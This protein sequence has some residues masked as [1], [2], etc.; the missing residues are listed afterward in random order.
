MGNQQSMGAFVAALQKQ[1]QQQQAPDPRAEI[2]KKRVEL[3]MSKNDTKGKQIN[4]DKLVPDEVQQRKTNEANAK[5]SQ[6]LAETER[7]FSIE[8]KLFD[9]TL[10]QL[11]TAANSPTYAIAQKYKQ[12]LQKKHQLIANQYTSNKEK[13]FTNR[14]RFLDSDPQAG[15]KG[16]VWLQTVDDQILA[17]FWIAYVLF[18]GT[19]LLMLLLEYGPQYLGTVK[20]IVI[21]GSITFAFLIFIADAAIKAYATD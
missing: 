4:F 21:V 16:F 7:Q 6:Y 15:V 17:V 11:D 18:V 10:A 1:Q 3:N 20:N 5:L 2:E 12:E 13:A 19:G 8:L 9:S 14:R